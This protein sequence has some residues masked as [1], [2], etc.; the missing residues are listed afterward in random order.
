MKSI[1]ICE[2]PSQAANVRAAVGDRFGRILAAQ[3]HLLRLEE[4]EEANPN[5]KRWNND[6][7]VP[8]AGRYGYA[9]DT[10]SGKAARLSDIKAALKDADQVIIATDCDREGQAIGQS[11]I[12]HFNFRGKVLRA[13]FTAEDAS[14]LTAA[15]DGARNNAEYQSLFDSAVARQ[16][17]DQIFNL[18]LTRVATNALRSPGSKQVIGIGRVKTPTLGIVCMRE[19]E[20]RDFKSRAFYEIA[21][22]VARAD[23]AVELWH[24]P[25]GD[26][27]VIDK[28]LATA[29]EASARSYTGVISIQREHKR[30]TPPQPHDLPSLQKAAGKWGWS[31]KKVLDTLQALYE[32]HKL[33]TYPRS[34][35]RFLPESMVN[36]APQL[37]ETLR[38]RYARLAPGGATIRAAVYSDRGLAGA[39]H[40]AVIPNVNMAEHMEVGIALLNSDEAKLF[41]LVACGWLAS[42]SPDF[43]YDETVMSFPV[44]VDNRC[45]QFS[46]TGRV[47]TNAGWKKVSRGTADGEVD[48][49]ASEE[50]P[51]LPPLGDGAAVRATSARILEKAT[52]P[53]GRYTEG[54]LVDA[55]KN[56][57]RFLPEGGERDRLKG[58][59]G[60]GTPATRDTV[61]EGLKAQ[62]LLAVV[63]GK[64]VPTEMGLWLFVLL[65]Q[66]A[67]A[68]VDPGATARMEGLLDSVLVG[69][70]SVTAVLTAIVEETKCLV[71]SILTAG[72]TVDKPKAK[73]APTDAMVTAARDKMKR[74]GI[75]RAPKGVMDDFDTCRSFLGPIKDRGDGPLMASEKQ[76]GLIK[77]LIAK[78][79]SAPERLA[80]GLTMAAASKWIDSVFPP[81]VV[82]K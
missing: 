12:E 26:G 69:G 72:A 20:I 82:T 63:K 19:L 40:H 78:G 11:L 48:E 81:K 51:A 10:G 80:D 47:E 77:N 39:S 34:E 6:V 70:T 60:I 5:W 27:R 42:I 49:A 22:T 71:T 64:I 28:S 45:Y 25:K 1:V 18:T 31:A 23:G 54:D 16:Q 37:L 38:P 4:P 13:M 44:S 46:T 53:P 67:A 79:H 17:A 52:T 33:T 50:V 62:Q 43:E 15:F 59:K 61:I 55:M 2:K 21:A 75:K 57:W 73:R 29:I 9:A 35:T 58:A 8:P 74:D 41:D 36:Q 24:R 56:A 7:L 66:A 3:G 76:L 30:S 65:K 32:T 68:L 14:S